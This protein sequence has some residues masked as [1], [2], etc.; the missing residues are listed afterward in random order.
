MLFGM[1]DGI[2]S[3]VSYRSAHVGREVRRVVAL[4]WAL[5]SA[6]SMCDERLFPQV[7]E[8][9]CKSRLQK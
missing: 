3:P 2:V 1:P 6:L 9:V 4:V 5:S 7:E 8:R